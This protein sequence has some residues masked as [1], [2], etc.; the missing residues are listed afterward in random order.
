MVDRVII[1]KGEIK[2]LVY[3]WFQ[4]RGQIMTNEY[5]VKWNIMVD[6]LRRD[7]T[8]GA[9]VRLVTPISPD[10]SEASADDRLKAMLASEW[11]I[12]GDYIPN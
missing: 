5:V 3:Y 7:R 2:Q 6:A 10:E 8:D 11:G 9:L 12:L 1:Q 4:Q